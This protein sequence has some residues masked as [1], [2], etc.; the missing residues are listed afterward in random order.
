MST[1]LTDLERL[2]KML[3]DELISPEEFSKLKAEVLSQIPETAGTVEE[4]PGSQAPNSDPAASI[5]SIGEQKQKIPTLYKV[6]LGLGIASALLGGFFGLL[7]W[8]TVGFS[9]WALYSLKD[10]NRRWMAW[11][12]LA[13]GIVFSLSNAYL[14][15]HLDS[16]FEAT[17][18]AESTQLESA[19]DAESTQAEFGQL[20]DVP[21][22]ATTMDFSFSEIPERWE[23]VA[24]FLRED[25]D[26]NA[27]CAD[28]G[29]VFPSVGP[30]D[31]S[32][33]ADGRL[34]FFSAPVGQ[35]STL[36]G[37]YNA[38]TELVSFLAV[39]T[40]YPK[41]SVSNSEESPLWYLLCG[42]VE[43]WSVATEGCPSSIQTKAIAAT[44]NGEPIVDITELRSG[45][46]WHA[47]YL[48]PFEGSST[49]TWE[50]NVSASP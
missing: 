48:P 29:I 24:N 12:G 37:S 36:R 28:A 41:P 15:G 50:L 6:A 4:P 11:T 42:V 17:T 35:Y 10:S 16:L 33:P 5:D 43:T 30:P 31:V 1:R 34:I 18:D 3:N 9:V 26:A 13:L 27:A 46:E 47:I 25:C 38:S 23:V 20:Q 2:Q 7:A 32:T 19:A 14:N 39:T 21:D 40:E 22:A 8:V 45:R 44:E 49:T